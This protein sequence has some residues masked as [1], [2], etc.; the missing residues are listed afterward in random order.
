MKRAEIRAKLDA[1]IAGTT[2]ITGPT[3][4]E[5]NEISSLTAQVEALTNQNITASGTVV[6]ATKILDLATKV[7][8][9]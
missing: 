3:T 9:A 5:V 7:A 1:L 6:L 2:T 4:E 8:S